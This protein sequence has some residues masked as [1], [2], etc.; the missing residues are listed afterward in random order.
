MTSMPMRA[1]SVHR[2]D[3]GRD[4]WEMVS[5]RPARH[6]AGAVGTYC[7]YAERTASFTARRELAAT[8]GVL[9][10]NLGEPIELTGA[11]GAGIVLRAGEGF[12]A[13]VA[14]GTS[15]SRSGGCQAGLHVAAPLETLAAATGAPAAEIANRVVRLQDI[16]GRAAR[17]LGERLHD[18]DDAET[19]FGLL[20]AFLERQLARAPAIHPAI[21]WAR[22]R[23]DSPDPPPIAELARELGW[24]RK[25]LSMRFRALTG[26]PPDTYRQLARFERFWRSL[27]SNPDESLAGLAAGAGYHDQAHLSRDVRAF[28]AMTPRELRRRLIPGQGGVFHEA[29]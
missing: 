2:Y 15:I 22:R 16:A 9:L 19:R 28:G 21:V 20:D 26:F 24:S 5:V 7:A 12:V 14:D 18:A 29:R 6:L 23:L 11:D 10:F 17:E 13:G 27:R 1:C 3:D 4:R 25:H 8:T